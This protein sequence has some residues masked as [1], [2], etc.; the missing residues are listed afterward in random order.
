MSLHVEKLGLQHYLGTGE[1]HWMERAEEY[2]SVIAAH[3]ILTIV[4]VGSGLF[5]ELFAFM[6]LYSRV[7]AA[8][9]GVSLIA[10]HLIIIE[11]MQLE[12]PLNS[13]VLA[14]FFV[15][16]PFVL[17]WLARKLGAPDDRPPPG[18]DVADGLGLWWMKKRD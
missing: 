7:H 4:V 14:V 8:V 17:A 2:A 12:F 10:M 1:K 5:F 15:N 6:A 11:V 13:W 18:E 9:F 3:P 16:L